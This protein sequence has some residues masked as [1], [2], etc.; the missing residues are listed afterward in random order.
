[1]ATKKENEKRSEDDGVKNMTRVM[2]KFLYPS[3]LINR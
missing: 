1:M 3:D 2:D